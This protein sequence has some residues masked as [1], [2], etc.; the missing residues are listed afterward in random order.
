MIL[1]FGKYKGHDTADPDIPVTY[2]V[3][4]EEQEWVRD[5]LREDLN[6]EIERREGDRPGAGKNTGR[7]F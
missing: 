6:A 3:W 4:L 2:L 5:K 7:R 1:P